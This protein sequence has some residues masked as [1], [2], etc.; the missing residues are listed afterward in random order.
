MDRIIRIGAIAIALAVMAAA[1]LAASY[2]IPWSVIDG[3]GG[4]RSSASYQLDDSIGQTAIGVTTSTS[5]TLQAGFL[6]GVPFSFKTTGSWVKTGWNC[7]SVPVVP[8]ST[9]PVAVFTGI[10]VASSSFQYW[11]NNTVGGGWQSYGALFGWTGPIERGTPYWFLNLNPATDLNVSGYPTSGP[12]TIQFSSLSPAPHWVMFGHMQSQPVNAA[13]ITF[14]TTSHPTAMNWQ[15]A[16]TNGVVDG[17]AMGF[18]NSTSSFFT[19]GPSAFLPQRPNLEPWYG[20]WLLINTSDAVT[21][22]F[23]AP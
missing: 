5:Y 22:T 4:H 9:D 6:Y 3:G 18:E 14:S 13:S 1:A 20:Y 16:N 2:S 17:T 23:P 21:M 7:V 15:D 19:A 11:K 8:E 12:Q 10:D